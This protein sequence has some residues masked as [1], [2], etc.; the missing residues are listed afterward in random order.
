MLSPANFLQPSG[1]INLRGQ[2]SAQLASHNAKIFGLW[3]TTFPGFHWE[4]ANFFG[5]LLPMAHPFSLL[6][7]PDD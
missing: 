6:K 2:H 4:I 5:S 1:L 7:W 3:K